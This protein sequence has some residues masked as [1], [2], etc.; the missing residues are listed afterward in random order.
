AAMSPRQATPAT[1]AG[2]RCFGLYTAAMAS[3]SEAVSRLAIG[4]ETSRAIRAASVARCGHRRRAHADRL[5]GFQCPDVERQTGNHEKT[6]EID[7]NGLRRRGRP[8]QKA[9]DRCC[10]AGLFFHAVVLFETGRN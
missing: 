8:S 6:H 5:L 4:S 7:R 2:A 1:A 9:S 3:I 10:R